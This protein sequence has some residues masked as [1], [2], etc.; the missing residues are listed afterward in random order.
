MLSFHEKFSPEDFARNDGEAVKI[1]SKKID[2]FMR[3]FENIYFE[4]L[5]EYDKHY[6]RIERLIQGKTTH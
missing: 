5:L 3:F 2:Q 6:E 4:V 1:L